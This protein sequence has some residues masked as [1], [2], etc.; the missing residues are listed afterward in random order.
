MAEKFPVHVVCAWTGNTEKIAS[1][2]YLQLTDEHF[3]EGAQGDEE[4]GAKGGAKCGAKCGADAVQKPVQ[5]P[6]ASFCTEKQ[7]TPQAIMGCGVVRDDSLGCDPLRDGK[8][9]PSGVE[10]LFSD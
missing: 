4:G 8:I 9:P 7:G 3:R 1:K 10:P 6:A 2:Y 5:Q